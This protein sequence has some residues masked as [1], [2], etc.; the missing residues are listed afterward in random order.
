MGY[1]D[2]LIRNWEHFQNVV[3]YIRRNPAKLRPGGFLAGESEMA[4]R[5]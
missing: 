2:R 4:K 3:R 5:F 1:H